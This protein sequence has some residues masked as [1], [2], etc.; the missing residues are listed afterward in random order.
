MASDMQEMKFNFCKYQYHERQGL[1][2]CSTATLYLNINTHKTNFKSK[3]QNQMIQVKSYILATVSTSNNYS[4]W[5]H[6]SCI[7]T[8]ITENRETW[9]CKISTTHVQG[10]KRDLTW[11]QRHWPAGNHQC[12]NV[13]LFSIREFLMRISVCKWSIH[14][15]FMLIPQ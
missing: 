5:T 12:L 14:V 6:N 3:N 1:H 13:Q 9:Y 8:Y 2:D 10:L 7:H 15:A 4:M 11:L